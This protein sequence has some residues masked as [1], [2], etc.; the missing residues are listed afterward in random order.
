MNVIKRDGRV[1]EFDPSKVFN[2]II[3]AMSSV[4]NCNTTLAQKI[5]DEITRTNCN[6]NVETIQDMIENKLMAS[7]CKDVAKAFII[8]RNDR[9]K[10]RER[11]SSL[12]QKVLERNSGKNIQ[13]SNANV[14][15]RS[16][17]GRE[18]EASSDIQKEIALDYIMSKD[19]S[20]AHKDGYIYHHD[21]DKYNLGMH[22]CLFLD[23][24]NIFTNG[25]STRN[26]DVRP[27][28]SF[29]TA[30]QLVAVA[31]QCQSQVQYGGVASCHLDYDLNLF[32]KLSFYKHYADGCKYI[33][34]LDDEQ[35]KT[36]IAYAKKKS[37]SITDEYFTADEEIYTYAIDML[38]KECEQS[39]QGLY[40]NLNTLESRQGSQVPFT[41]INFGR[42]TSPEGR[43]VSKSMLDAS[44]DGIGKFHRTSIF[45]ISIFQYK[46]GTNANPDDPNYDLKQLA[47][48]SLSK[49]IYPNFVNGD[50]SQAHE[51]EKNPDTFAASMGCR[52]MI[53]YDRHGLG[54]SRVG[55]GNNNP[56]TIILPKIAI[57][58]GICTGKREVPDIEGFWQKFNEILNLV[59][60]AHLERFEIMKAQSPQA[61]PFMYNN[62]TIKDSDKCVDSVYES[63]KHNTFAIGYI[64]VAEMCQALFGKNHA[65]DDTVREFALSVVKRINE[66]ASE[67]SE[68]NNLNFSCYSTPAEG[69]CRTALKNLRDQYGIIENVTSRDYL[70]NSHHV[71]VWEKVSI[72]DKLRIEAPFCKY[73][74][75]GCITY[76]ELESTFMQNL[77][78]VEDIIDYAFKELDIPYLALNFPID[79]CLDCGYQEELNG[80]CPKCGSTNIEELRRVTG[81]LTTDWHKFNIGKQH[82]VQERVKHTAYTDLS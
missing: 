24:Y 46:Q 37:L 54:Y 77:K 19:I 66:F 15:E 60:K 40:H 42:D 18:K 31:F 30:C 5:T 78:A 45:P 70:T 27:P 14:D 1:V 23:F 69:L 58:Y 17:S 32:I 65:Q 20:N 61:A 7:N 74:T 4:N 8:Y 51:D 55:R 50:W 71:P 10:E 21:L 63:L 13:N 6:M 43:L 34:H 53:G 3:K 12:I 47:L 57:E 52:T 76:I 16:F 39:A 68:R 72:Y 9:T 38:V 33:G 82:E 75:G 80:K 22:N 59:E 11:N 81:Y 29:S 73:P 79:T 67:A 26:G 28:T 48:K 2:A 64:G 35:I 49:R 56:I 41:S 62:G 25:F 44:I 36:I